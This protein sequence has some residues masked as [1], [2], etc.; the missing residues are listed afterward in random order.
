M[1][2]TKNIELPLNEQQNDDEIGEKSSNPF[3]EVKLYLL[4]IHILRV[5]KIIKL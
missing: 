1:N 3:N 5:F 2:S 4:S